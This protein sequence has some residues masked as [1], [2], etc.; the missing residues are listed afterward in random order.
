MIERERERE[1]EG[2]REGERVG[3]RRRKEDRTDLIKLLNVQATVADVS[4][5]L[6]KSY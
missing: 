3:G 6:S 5:Y 1:R 4:S 2:E